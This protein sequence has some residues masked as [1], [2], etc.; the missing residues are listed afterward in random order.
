MADCSC[1][2]EVIVV[3][4]IIVISGHTTNSKSGSVSYM[5]HTTNITNT[6]KLRKMGI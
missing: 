5:P 2:V 6:V 1:I 4:L 3:A